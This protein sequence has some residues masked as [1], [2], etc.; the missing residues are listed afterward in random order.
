[1]I[2]LDT[3]TLVWLDSGDTRLG[4]QSL[5]NIE[6]A[7]EA[8]QLY[9]CAISFWEIAML[10]KKNRLKMNIAIEQW[11]KKL[12]NSGLQELKL[13]GDVAIQAGNFTELHGDPADR[14]IIAST[15]AIDANLCTADEK[16]IAWMPEAHCLDARV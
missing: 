8:H 3:H 12:L 13:S 7:F 11:R 9:V 6:R 15:L 2:V 10:V 16:I 1:M 4:K 5:T 14:M